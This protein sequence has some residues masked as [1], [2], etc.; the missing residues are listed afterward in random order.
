MEASPEASSVSETAED[1]AAA[2]DSDGLEQPEA[3]VSEAAVEPAGSDDAEVTEDVSPPAAGWVEGR[4]PEDEDN[5]LAT[6]PFPPEDSEPVPP[7]RAVLRARSSELPLEVA[8][9]LG[10][11]SDDDDFLMGG[12]ERPARKRSGPNY[13]V[14]GLV[15]MGMLCGMLG[16]MLLLFAALHYNG[17]F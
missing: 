17:V 5:Q 3:V 13:L 9:D 15:G 14:W 6:R 10:E 7:T 2:P 11:G 4:P 8:P 16:C 1:A 12:G